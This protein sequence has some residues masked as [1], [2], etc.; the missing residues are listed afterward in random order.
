MLAVLRDDSVVL[1]P[2]ANTMSPKICTSAEE[3]FGIKRGNNKGTC[4]RSHATWHPHQDLLISGYHLVVDKVRK[5]KL[6]VVDGQSGKLI[7]TIDPYRNHEY[8]FTGDDK[9][10]FGPVC[11]HCT[12]NAFVK[13][14]HDGRFLICGMHRQL[15]SK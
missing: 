6:G 7:T 13:M 9:D 12:I 15:H 3:W 8:I 2:N 10:E 5:E 1:Y 11:E 14:N 4:I